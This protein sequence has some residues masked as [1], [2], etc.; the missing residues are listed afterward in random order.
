[1]RRWLCA[2]LIGCWLVRAAVAESGAELVIN[3]APHPV[4]ATMVGDA[5]LAD[6]CFVNRSCGWAV[7]ERGVI[8]HTDDGGGTWR[9]QQ[10]GVTCR[11]DSVCF[12]DDRHGWA[13]GGASRPH[14]NATQGVVLRTVDG[15]RT[16]IAM[17]RLMLPRLVQVKFFNAND[18]VA[19]GAGSTFFP[20][21]VF[22]TRDGGREWQ[23]LP[24]D[25][26]GQWLTGDFLDADTGAVAGSAGR[27]ATMARRQVIHSPLASSSSRSFHAMRLIAPTGGWLVGDGGLVMTTGDLGRSWQTPSSELPSD[28]FGHFDFRALAVQGPHVWITGS[29]G[30]RVFHSGDGGKSWQAFATGQTVPLRAL[31]FIDDTHGW[32]VGELGSI[33]ATQDGGQSWQVQRSGGRRAAL[34]AVFADAADVPL[35]VVA[36][37]GAAEGYLTAVEILHPTLAG[38]AVAADIGAVDRTRE[39]AILAGATAAHTAW[40]FPLPPDDLA[41]GPKELLDALNRA[42]DGRALQRLQSHFVTQ[43]RM[44]RPDV[45]VT[46]HAGSDGGRPIAGL[47]EQLLLR[48]IDAAADPTRAV[49]LATNAGLEP[50]QVKKAYGVLPSGLRGDEVVSSGRF[51]ARLGGSLADWTA[52]ARRLLVAG[53]TTPPDSIELELML[54]RLSETGGP[55][56]LFN[57]ITL[58]PD[59]EAR[60]PSASDIAGDVDDLRRLAMRRRNLRELLER[61]AGNAAW[62]GQVERLVEGLDASGSGELLF[63]LADGYRENGRLDLAADTFY[64]LARRYPDHPLADPALVWLVQFYASSEAVRRSAEAGV[65]DLR[66]GEAAEPQTIDQEVKQANAVAPIGPAA[67]PAIGL[68]RDDRLRRAVQLGEYLESSRPLLFAE[69][70]LRYPLVA[71]QRQL[72][73]ANP[74]KRYFLSL[75]QLPESDPW[76]RCAQT[77]QWLA[78][79]GELP[80]PKMLGHCRLAPE[81]PHLDGI[82]DEPFWQSADVLWLRGRESFST[83]DDARVERSPVEKESRPPTV[84]LAYDAEYLYL[85]ITCPKVEGGDYRLNDDPR[86]R[87]A[88]LAEHDRVS[89]RLD[90]DRDFTT[91]LELTVDHRGWTRDACWGDSHWNPTWFVAAADEAAAW[92]IEAAV[93]LGELVVEPPGTKDV[94]AVGVRRT[95]PRVGCQSWSG[96]AADADSPEQFG[97]LIFE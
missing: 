84:R 27:F 25:Q 69:P 66:A 80:P 83:G 91:W 39:A 78:K 19:I 49:D 11:L 18:G 15:G 93:P 48:S 76:R 5:A 68:S 21:G 36:D 88:D 10:S 77:E 86:P 67:A 55:R 95:I 22:V 61:N 75:G 40:Q 85:A 70:T 64:L 89:L 92:T 73:F 62:V 82:L 46:H 34:L 53:G 6:V 29:P 52:P 1:M 9:E 44:W 72:G 79:P 32:V 59:G 63:Q 12:L 38:D 81:R 54:N 23:P 33:L 4:A 74:A 50:W 94:W 57:G 16:W 26:S 28:V 43:L 20:S 60:R 96:N 17:P 42:N 30:T 7:G 56:G 14:S 3:N 31:S 47:V 71:A 90:V 2:V 8:W 58:S 41:L 51:S 87:D 13:V 35:E 45:V 65:V 37:Q 97:F 24:G